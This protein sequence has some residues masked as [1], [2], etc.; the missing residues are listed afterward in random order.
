MPSTLIRIGPA[1]H[2]RRMKLEDFD[3]CVGKEGHLYEL[4]RGVVTVM[5]VPRGRHF[6]QVQASRDQFILHRASHPHQIHGIAGGAE[7]KLLIDDLHSERHPDVAVYLAAMPP[8]DNPWRAW[9]PKIVLE[10]VSPSSKRRDYQEKPE[11]YLR[12]GVSE[13]WI[14]DYQRREMLILRRWGSRWIEKT[15]R[16]P[17][18]YS[19][20]LL[21]GF[22]FDC[23]AVFAAA[24]GL[25]R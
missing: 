15:V 3:E 5:Q 16:P 20:R 4:S 8:L 25:R 22:S 10:V 6:V 23:A 19:T 17:E 21:P 12:L 18:K 2:G 24:D 14:I 1:D 11:E 7:C 9:I 13:Y